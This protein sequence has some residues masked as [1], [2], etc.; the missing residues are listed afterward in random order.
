M[1]S[2]F[3]RPALRARSARPLDFNRRRRPFSSGAACRLR[4]HPFR[5]PQSLLNACES[6]KVD[7]PPRS[8]F[9]TQKKTLDGLT[10]PRS[11]KSLYGLPRAPSVV[12]SRPRTYIQAPTHSSRNEVQRF[13]LWW[14]CGESNSG[15]KHIPGRC[16]QAQSPLRSQT[17]SSGDRRFPPQLVQT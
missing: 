8:R 2:F 6:R 17:G 10:H 13:L 16:L 5:L 11:Q 4:L 7:L 9:K 15:P 14:R 12:S 1:L 3:C